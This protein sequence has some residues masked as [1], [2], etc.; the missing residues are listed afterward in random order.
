MSDSTVERMVCGLRTYLKL[1]GVWPSPSYQ[2]TRTDAEI[3][4]VIT[5]QIAYL[6]TTPL[7]A[8]MFICSTFNLARVEEVEL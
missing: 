1:A 6:S 7:L 2:N 5:E 4:A 8:L 3:R